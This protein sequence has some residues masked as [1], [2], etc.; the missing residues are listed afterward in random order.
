MQVIKVLIIEE[1]SDVKENLKSQL[2]S[3]NDLLILG[4]F[5]YGSEILPKIIALKPDVILIDIDVPKKNSIDL[6]DELKRN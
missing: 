2:G 5:K 3:Q 1:N 6:I 4:E